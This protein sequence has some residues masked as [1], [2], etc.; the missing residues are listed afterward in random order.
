MTT[1]AYEKPFS[2]IECTNRP[3]RQRPTPQRDVMPPRPPVKRSE[4]VCPGDVTAYM[5]RKTEERKMKEKQSNREKLKEEK[6]KREAIHGIQERNKKLYRR[7]GADHHHDG[8][9]DEDAFVS[10]F[11]Q[12]YAFQQRS[13]ST[14]RQPTIIHHPPSNASK[15]APQPSR[16]KSP[17][18]APVKSPV[19]IP[20]SP[21]R[22][23]PPRRAISRRDGIRTNSVQ[24]LPSEIPTSSAPP[25]RPYTSSTFPARNF[26][27]SFEISPFITRGQKMIL[28]PEFI[29]PVTL[30]DLNSPQPKREKQP[31]TVVENQW[32]RDGSGSCGPTHGTTEGRRPIREALLFAKRVATEEEEE[33]VPP[34]RDPSQD[35]M[36]AISSQA[37]ELSQR[38]AN[39]YSRVATKE[40]TNGPPREEPLSRRSQTREEQFRQQQMMEEQMR[41]EQMREE[42]MREEQMREEK[43]REIAERMRLESLEREEKMFRD[44]LLQRERQTRREAE[45]QLQ[46]ERLQRE[47]RLSLDREQMYREPYVYRG[48]T[49]QPPLRE[50][51]LN[52]RGGHMYDDSRPPRYSDQS[53]P[54]YNGKS[55]ENSIYVDHVTSPHGTIPLGRVGVSDRFA[56]RFLGIFEEDLMEIQVY[57]NREKNRIDNEA[58]KNIQRIFRGFRVRIWLKRNQ[59]ILRPPYSNVNSRSNDQPKAPTTI[60]QSVE[61]NQP[62]PVPVDPVELKK[63]EISKT[64]KD[65]N[66]SSP[67]VMG[68]MPELPLRDEKREEPLHVDILTEPMRSTSPPSPFNDNRVLSH[69]KRREIHH[70]GDGLNQTKDETFHS[71]NHPSLHRTTDTSPTSIYNPLDTI[72]SQDPAFT[73][74]DSFSSPRHSFVLEEKRLASTSN[75]SLIE[76]LPVRQWVDR[77]LG[78]EVIG[79]SMSRLAGLHGSGRLPPSTRTLEEPVSIVVGDKMSIV[80]LLAERMLHKEKSPEASRRTNEI[81]TEIPT[82]QRVEEMRNSKSDFGV[83]TES[84]MNVSAQIVMHSLPST[85]LPSFT[86]QNQSEGKEEEIERTSARIER[87]S[88]RRSPNPSR[89]SVRPPP[90]EAPDAL[91]ERM[92]N[93]INLLDNYN[94]SLLQ[95]DA[96]SSTR[97]INMAQHETGL[98]YST[99]L[100]EKQLEQ[101]RLTLTNEMRESQ[102]ASQRE[103]QKIQEASQREIER[104][105]DALKREEARRLEDEMERIAKSIE[106]ESERMRLQMETENEGIRR[107]LEKEKKKQQEELSLLEDQLR[108]TARRQADL[109][110]TDEERRKREREE[111]EKKEMERIEQRRMVNDLQRQLEEVK[112]TAEYQMNR[113]DSEINLQM[114]EKQ[115]E[116]VEKQRDMYEKQQAQMEHQ[117][118]TAQ[119]VA[120]QE[121]ME[122]SMKMQQLQ[123]QIDTMTTQFKRQERDL[124]LKE[125]AIADA[126]LQ[127]DRQM[128]EVTRARIKMEEDMKEREERLKQ[129]VASMKSTQIVRDIQIQT[130]TDRLDDLREYRRGYSSVDS[131]FMST[132]DSSFADDTDSEYERWKKEKKRKKEAEVEEQK[133]KEE[134]REEKKIEK[135]AERKEEKTE[136]REEKKLEKEKVP[137]IDKRERVSIIS[138]STDESE[139]IRQVP[140]DAPQILHSQGDDGESKTVTEDEVS[141]AVTAKES[142]EEEEEEEESES[143]ESYETEEE[144]E[145]ESEEE[146]PREKEATEDE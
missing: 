59:I 43:T 15:P 7:A 34:G 30:H 108:E 36:K 35:R 123:M 55:S 60:S 117:R 28:S 21:T 114:M 87:P 26:D 3:E 62:Q 85:R 141:D 41:V 120:K 63:S 27:E 22:T 88:P 121:Q 131:S 86:F 56:V 115:R 126:T 101:M 37:E 8:D 45:L 109:I 83:Q 140:R 66:I 119:M 107:Q 12:D 84:E 65:I 57:L 134:K 132:T 73:S 94:E 14:S 91:Y 4:P 106:A 9:P 38:I 118:L 23:P 113:K 24:Q 130:E 92:Q 136:K 2:N 53:R 19:R 49:T 68:E 44:K 31:K 74:V 103:M 71:L 93:E 90:R 1:A 125:Q 122:S 142:E 116:M 32:R 89:S 13:F 146:T 144:E 10:G 52:E 97:A 39:L 40:R 16:S 51:L 61:Y 20:S 42:Q 54:L 18:R 69:L 50:T 76:I 128:E 143:D 81:S 110:V 124:E 80:N 102:A 72:H 6:R 111:G 79:G 95:L 11:A 67:I 29:Q 46:R 58:A 70:D 127:R 25:S 82:L 75:L 133:E 77:T 17:V 129:A 96:L 139:T 99:F 64:E 47:Q 105:Q 135:K 33:K 78:A 48:E 137:K 145:E 5:R 112:R 104:L 98:L 138:S 100:H